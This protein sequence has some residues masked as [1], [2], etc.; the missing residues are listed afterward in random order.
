MH[1]LFVPLNPTTSALPLQLKNKN[2][3]NKI[4]N[5]QQMKMDYQVKATNKNSK[6]LIR[7]IKVK[8]LMVEK[9]KRQLV[10]VP[11]TASLSEAMAELAANEV[12]TVPVV[13]PPGQWIGAGGSMIVESDKETG[14]V[15]KHYI[16]MVTMLDIV[17]HIAGNDHMSMTLEDDGGI[18][19]MKDLNEKMC[20]PVSSIIGHCMESLSLWTLNPNTRFVIL[21]ICNIHN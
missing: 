19:I 14:R 9:K 7:E 18:G 3:V 10:E 1:A 21:I 15:K 17:A 20:A 4:Q 8:D 11:Y 13:A 2:F 6:G 12:T 16:G 5:M